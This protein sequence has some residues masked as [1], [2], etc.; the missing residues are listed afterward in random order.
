M[1]LAVRPQER[2]RLRIR[3]SKANRFE[4]AVF[5]IDLE[6]PPGRTTFRLGTDYPVPLSELNGAALIHGFLYRA[7]GYRQGAIVQMLELEARR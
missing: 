7:A 3:Y 6:C 1:L 2:K 4:E 5:S